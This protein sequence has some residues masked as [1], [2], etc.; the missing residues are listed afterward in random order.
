MT[1]K[2]WLHKSLHQMTADEWE[3]LCDG[4]GKC[5]LVKLQDED[6]DEVFYT[7][8]A[9]Q[10]LGDDCRCGVYPGRF[11]YQPDCVNLTAES[12]MRDLPWLPHS[13]SYRLIAENKPLPDWH[14]LLTGSR[15]QMHEEG[16]SVRGKVCSENDVHE[17]DLHE[18]IV[19]WVGNQSSE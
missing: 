12:V 7:H 9:C 4:C 17:D 10:F 18:C 8:V 15:Q 1:E 2:F 11:Q 3:V 6:T 5:C 14:P 19:H 16:Y 13:C